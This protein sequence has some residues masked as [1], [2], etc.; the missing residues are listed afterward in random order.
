[1]NDNDPVPDI[2]FPEL[3]YRYSREGCM[4]RL[5]NINGNYDILRRVC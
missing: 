3:I 5:N 1:M 4:L 2:P